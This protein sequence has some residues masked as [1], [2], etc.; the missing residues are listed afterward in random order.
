[1]AERWQIRRGSTLENNGFTG[2]QGEL[3]MDTD[4]KQLRVHDGSTQGGAGV[5]DPVVAFQR[6]TAENGYTWFRKYA[7]G[8]VEQ[9]GWLDGSTSYKNTEFGIPVQMA[10]DKYT[11]TFAT[12]NLEGAAT[13][14]ANGQTTT[15]FKIYERVWVNAWYEHNFQGWWK[16]EGQAA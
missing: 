13:V 15:G 12:Y 8:W 6:P 9:G 16:V 7:S 4:T 11:L 14:P 10:N 1:M 3:T 2:A 5:I